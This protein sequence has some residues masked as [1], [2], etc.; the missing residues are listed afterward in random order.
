MK[1]LLVF[2]AAIL[3]VFSFFSINNAS[4]NIWAKGVSQTSGWFDAE[5]D[6]VTTDDNLLCWAASGSNI[7]SW[8]GWNAGYANEDAIFDWLTVEDPVDQGGW[9]SYAWNFWFTGSTTGPHYVG[10][11]HPGF[12]TTAE[13]NA[14]LIQEW[15]NSDLD[16]AMDLAAGWLEDDYGVGIAIKGS[17][18]YHAVTLWGIDT[19]DSGNYLGVWITDSD[20][21][22]NG[23]DP[24]PN[25][26]NYYSVSYGSDDLWYLD[27]GGG[28]AIWEME[29]LK[30]AEVEPVPEPATM[31]LLGSGLLGL[32]ALRRRWFKKS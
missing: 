29:G 7:L 9:Q 22:K 23:P 10:S 18:F 30:M 17:N 14:A 21:S 1:K 3:L 2:L 6:N 8:S 20:N 4:A 11:T 24:R 27:Y 15:D 28:A 32:G 12:Y 16:V 26:L 19:D 13:Y 31:L 25:T 5:K